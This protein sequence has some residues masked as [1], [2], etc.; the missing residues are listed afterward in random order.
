MVKLTKYELR[1][2]AKNRG[3]NNYPNMSREELLSTLDKLE[4]I[5]EDLLNN[6]Y[7]KITKMQNL[8]LDQLEKPEIMNNLSL[9][10][11][12]QLSVTENIKNYK[13]MSKEDLLITLLKSNKSNTELLNN[14]DNNIEIKR[15]KKLFNKLENNFLEDEI[16]EVTEKINK[17]ER[18]YN[19]LKQA[20]QKD[21][22]PRKRKKVLKRIEEYFRKLK[23]DL[24][25]LKRPRHNIDYRKIEN[26]FNEINNDDY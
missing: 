5:T 6:G 19:Y 7:N 14:R 3:I 10:K 11:L 2:I 9:E 20:E 4:R 24:D 23:E 1:L 17:K 26:L 16:N 22:L 8:S 12:K 15:T 25:K 18:T 21:T 13:N